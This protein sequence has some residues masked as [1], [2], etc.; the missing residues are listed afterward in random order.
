MAGVTAP[1]LVI[2]GREDRVIPVAVSQ[3][4]FDLLPHSELHL[5]RN[6][7]NWTQIEKKDRFNALVG[8][9]LT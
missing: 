3:R 4:L 1:T 6:C 2:H 8:G 7:G 9:F 5:F